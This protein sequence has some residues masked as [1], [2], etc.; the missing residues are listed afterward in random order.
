MTSASFFKSLAA[1]TLAV[2]FSASVSAA[3]I[4]EVSNQDQVV[5][6]CGGAAYGLYTNGL[7]LGSGS[8]CSYYYSINPGTNFTR[9]DD[10]TASFTGTATNQFGVEATINLNLFGFTTDYSPVKTGG[11]SNTADWGF[12]TNL[13][14]DSSITIDGTEYFARL[15]GAPDNIGS[16][17]VFQYGTGAN[18][19]TGEFGGSVWLDMYSANGD[20][21]FV[22]P[23]HWDINF[24]LGPGFELDVPAPAT[25]GL[26][27]LGIAALRFA[28]KR[29]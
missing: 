4:H 27:A 13:T 22:E 7:A 1:T 16:K 24:D 5:S 21:L 20:A 25:A 14:E 11:G 23:N 26:L 2:S 19:K 18:D 8:Y 12:Y 29:K 9:F 17:P 6:S 28:R 15:V 10:G 3:I